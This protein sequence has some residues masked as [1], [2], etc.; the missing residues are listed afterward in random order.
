MEREE[1]ITVLL[2]AGDLQGAATLAIEGY[3]PEVLGFLVTLLRDEGDASE[4]FSQ[5]CED[6]W[7]GLARFEGRS[8]FR[9]WFYTLAR[10]AAA[11][12]RRSPQQAQRRRVPLSEIS[13]VAAGVRSRTLPFLRNEVK[14][15]FEE[16]R[17]ALDES[18]R[19]LLVL[20]VDRNMDWREIARVFS[21][22]VDSEEELARV[23]ARLRKRFQLVKEEIR[24]R[25]Q[26]LGLLHENGP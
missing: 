10:H 14:D 21:A 18:D 17:A 3:G 12:L 20:R 4:A 15:R 5:A 19:A 16:I 23:S 22:G 8:S 13:E 24:R 9:T 7:K 26:E 25:A 6:L 2:R 1:R 11:R